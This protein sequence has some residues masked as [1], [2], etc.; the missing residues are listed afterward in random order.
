MVINKTGSDL[1]GNLTLQ[2]FVPQNQA[3]KVYQ[4]S[5]ANLNS[6]TN[7]PDVP[8]QP[9]PATGQ[10]RYFDSL[11]NYTFPANSITLLVLP[12]HEVPDWRANT[13]LQKRGR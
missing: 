13:I 10:H 2:K 5:Q 9:N 12:G 7:L 6:I 1:S 8:V 3:A 4:Y 11:I